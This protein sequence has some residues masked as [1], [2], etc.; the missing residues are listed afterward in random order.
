MSQIQKEILDQNTIAEDTPLPQLRPRDFSEYIGQGKAK[1]KI[2]LFIEAAKQRGEPLDHVLLSGPPG[3]GKTTMAHLICSELG[4]NLSATTGPALER[5]GDL[6][7]ILTNLKSRDILFIDEIHRTNR[8]VEEVLY[9]AM[10]DFKVDIIMGKGP[11][12]RNISLKLEPFTLIG[13][14]TRPSMLSSPLRTRFGVLLRLD[15][16]EQDELQE[17][18]LSAAKRLSIEITKEGAEEIARR[19]RGTPRIV[20]RILKRVRDYAQ[21][22]A[23]GCIT[24]EVADQA[25]N[26]LEIDSQGLDELDRKILEILIHN[27]GGG[28]LGLDTLAVALGEEGENIY[29]VYEPY[30]IKIGFLKRTPRGRVATGMAYRHLGL[31]VPD[32]DKPE[33]DQSELFS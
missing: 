22:R 10:E 4:V 26:M 28:P 3:L 14:T 1:E 21:I 9:S 23:S 24:G 6:A 15:Y 12:A 18:V 20:T 7:A 17:I 16:Y 33:P 19:G 5:V 25:L 31:P 2:L 30:L 32:S 8:V 11:S 13:A 27:Y 29:D